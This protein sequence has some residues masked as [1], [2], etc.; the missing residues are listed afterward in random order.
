M[1]ENWAGDAGGAVSPCGHGLSREWKPSI[2][3][4]LQLYYFRTLLVSYEPIKFPSL[5]KVIPVGFS[6]KQ[7]RHNQYKRKEVKAALKDGGERLCSNLCL[8]C[9]FGF[10]TSISPSTKS[11]VSLTLLPIPL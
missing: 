9:W 4:W 8:V 5:L 10:V 1:M 7:K 3:P 2:Q 6:Y 11:G